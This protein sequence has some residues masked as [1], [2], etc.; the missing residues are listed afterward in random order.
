MYT[1]VPVDTHYI[2]NEA[3]LIWS[4]FN[5]A[6]NGIKT[7]DSPPVACAITIAS[8]ELKHCQFLYHHA[9]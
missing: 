1:H 7:V 8:V 5:S 4:S 6:N 3:C 2:Y 9:P